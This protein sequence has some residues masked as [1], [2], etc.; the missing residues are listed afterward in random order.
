MATGAAIAITGQ[1]T[2]G[3]MLA[4]GLAVVAT[5]LGLTLVLEGQGRD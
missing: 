2:C 1:P 5:C 3:S 4:P